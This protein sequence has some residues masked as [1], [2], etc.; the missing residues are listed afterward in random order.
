MALENIEMKEVAGSSV[1]VM[2]ELRD[3]YPDKF[4]DSGAMDYKWFESDI[5]PKNFVYVRRDKNSIA[6]TIQKGPIKEHGVNGCQ[7]DALIDAAK[8]ILQHFNKT[9]PCRENSL[10][11]TKLEEAMLWL[12]ARKRNRE[13]RGVEGTSKP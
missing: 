6:F 11:I 13:Q 2:D 7:V 10:A 5:R 8:Q 1:I 4:N 12:N 9:Y 3:Q